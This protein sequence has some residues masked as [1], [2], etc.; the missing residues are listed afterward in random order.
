MDMNRCFFLK[1]EDRQPKWRVID[2]E[3][4]VLGRLATQIAD[5]L[6]GKDK[7]EYSQHVDVG[8]Y[9]VVIN[10]EKVVLTG[11]KMEDKIYKSYSGWRSGLKETTAKIMMQ[12]KPEEIIKH[13]V[14]GMLPKNRIS[15]Q[16]FKKLKIYVGNDHK[17]I[18]QVTK[19]APT[20]SDSSD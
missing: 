7:P 13:A 1:K 5:A 14:K 3:G 9:I 16:I 11:N 12:K 4:R 10:C 19:Y 18:A 20:L 6:R 2:A 8:D 15:R 17:H